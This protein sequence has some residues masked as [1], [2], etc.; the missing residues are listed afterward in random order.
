[1]DVWMYGCMDLEGPIAELPLFFLAGTKVGP[2][3]PNVCSFMV[4]RLVSYVSSSTWHWVKETTHVR[5]STA[6]CPAGFLIENVSRCVSSTDQDAGG[7]AHTSTSGRYDAVNTRRVAGRGVA[8]EGRRRGLATWDSWAGRTLLWGRSLAH[9][10]GSNTAVRTASMTAAVASGAVSGEREGTGASAAGTQ[11]D[12]P[13]I[14]PELVAQKI[15]MCDDPGDVF[16]TT[17][18]TSD[19]I[20]ELPTRYLSAAAR[21]AALSHITDAAFLDALLHRVVL[22]LG[23]DDGWRSKE[24]KG[25]SPADVCNIIESFSELDYCHSIELKTAVSRYMLRNLELFSGDMLGHTLRSFANLNFYDDELLERVL[26]YMSENAADFSAENVADD[27][28]AFSKCGFC[29]PDLISLVDQA[30]SMLLKEALHDNGEAIAGI[31]DAYSRVGCA[32]SETL[33]A[34]VEL[35]T[36]SPDKIPANALASTLASAIRLGSEDQGM[37]NRVLGSLLPRMNDL[38]TGVLVEVVVCLGGL[39]VRPRDERFLETLVDEVLPYR[40]GEMEEKQML[41][42][43]DGLNKLG[44]YVRGLGSL[45]GKEQTEDMP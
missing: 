4:P 21:A 14:K 22:S 18:I 9:R 29:H 26:T 38:E 31:V 36:Q 1:M 41:D 43:V 6:L 20:S 37:M 27:V 25:L 8:G 23:D 24:S 44:F 15:L 42:V 34:L 17:A 28:Y 11:A 3:D 16:G 45:M 40:I 7:A 32:E 10:G 2:K 12:D 19:A 13:G 39:G 35:V 33:D 5:Y 30:G